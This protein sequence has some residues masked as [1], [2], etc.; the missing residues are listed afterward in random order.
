VPQVTNVTTIVFAPQVGG[1]KKHFY[2]KTIYHKN[3]CEKHT[4]VM[5]KCESF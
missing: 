5:D 2:G 4:I 3:F 1:A